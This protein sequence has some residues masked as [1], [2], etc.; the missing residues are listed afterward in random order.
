MI[1]DE[2]RYQ[3][4]VFVITDYQLYN[5]P[6]SEARVKMWEDISSLMQILMR[7]GYIMVIYE[8]SENIVVIQY[9]HN[10]RRDPMGYA[11]PC[12]I[13]EDEEWLIENSSLMEED[14]SEP[15][16]EFA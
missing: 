6:A 5:E 14:N 1:N 13:T 9:E 15:P 2:K 10:E 16:S 7:A 8:D 3:E 4:I 11:N 12:W